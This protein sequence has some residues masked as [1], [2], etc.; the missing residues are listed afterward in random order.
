LFWNQQSILGSTMGD[1]QEME[2]S[3]ALLLGGHVAP[4]IDQVYAAADGAEA[5]A[6][7]EAGEQFGKLVLDWRG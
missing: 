4:V 7:M 1:M 5:V 2:A 3:M 6:C